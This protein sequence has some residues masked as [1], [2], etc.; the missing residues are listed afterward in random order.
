MNIV[1]DLRIALC[2][3]DNE[4]EC[5]TCELDK[6][7]QKLVN[8]MEQLLMAQ[9]IV[10]D[11]WRKSL[12]RAEEIKQLQLSLDKEKQ[13]AKRFW[14]LKCDQQLAHEEALEEKDNKIAR[15]TKLL[16]IKTTGDKR[17]N[18]VCLW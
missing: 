5:L 13:K 10:E 16:S 18:P 17:T 7:S 3:H 9:L 2:E 4:L 12:E 6:Q 14:H 8:V 11:E 1:S 15:L